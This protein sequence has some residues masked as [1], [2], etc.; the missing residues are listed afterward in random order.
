M[1][2]T[3]ADTFVGHVISIE[4]IKSLAVIYDRFANA[5]D[6]FSTER[7]DAE[8]VF[9][10]EVANLHD[11]FNDGTVSHHDF[12]KAIIVRCKRYLAAN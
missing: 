2:T 4:Q 6:P 10:Q 3:S 8:K 5:L 9:M 7:D 1:S 12:R 11:Y